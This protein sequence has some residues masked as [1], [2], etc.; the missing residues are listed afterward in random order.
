MRS[1]S[2]LTTFMS[3][4]ASTTTAKPM[5]DPPSGLA[6]IS[7]HDGPERDK[8]R[9]RPAC[10]RLF[11]EQTQPPPCSQLAG[12]SGPMCNEVLIGPDGVDFISA[13]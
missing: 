10:R 1:R 13:L 2:V 12:L 5:P 8:I 3:I 7:P 11:E 6:G 9:R 4:S